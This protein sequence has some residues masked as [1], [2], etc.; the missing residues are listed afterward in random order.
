MIR[1]I[2][3]AGEAQGHGVNE[4]GKLGIVRLRTHNPRLGG[5][6]KIEL[7]I[8]IGVKTMLLEGESQITAHI[9]IIFLYLLEAI[10]IGEKPGDLKMSGLIVVPPGGGKKDESCSIKKSDYKD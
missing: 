1:Q 2:Q 4:V 6:G 7:V 9:R 5:G 3:M 10:V 8:A